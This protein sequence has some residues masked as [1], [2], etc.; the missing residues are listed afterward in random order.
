[1]Y[2]DVDEYGL[3]DQRQAEETLASNPD[4]KFMLPVHLYG[5]SLDLKKLECLKDT[6]ELSIVEDCAQAIG[7]RS[8]G[9]AVGSIGQVAATSFYPTKNLGGSVMVAHC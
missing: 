5:H 6:Y 2:V 3:M 1:M 7:S 9:I 8:A 4:I